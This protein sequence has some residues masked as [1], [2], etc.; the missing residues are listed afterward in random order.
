MGRLVALNKAQKMVKML[1]VMGRRDGVLAS[2]LLERFDLDPR[3]LRRYLADLRELNVPVIDTGRGDDRVVSLD[4]SWRRTGVQLTLTEVLSL[5]FGRT[6]FNFLD[7]TS[8]A[9]DLDDAIERLEPAVSRAHSSLARQLDT[10]FLAILEHAKDY[11]SRS[12]VI[13]EAITALVYNNPLHGRYRKP[14]G[15]EK[16]YRLEPY[17][18][19]TY[20]RGL[21]LLARDADEGMVKTFALERFT[22]LRRDRRQHFEPPGGWSP[23]A[24]LADAFGIISGPPSDIRVAFAP[25]LVAYIR[26]RTW[27]PTQT[28]DTLP[29]GR[30]VLQLRVA[31]TIEL[32]TWVLSFG[33]AAQ[34]LGP[35]SLVEWVTREVRAA[36]AMYTDV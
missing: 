24:H 9:R 19:A 15:V 26:E 17:T 20:R 7:G 29:D 30:L 1:R 12:D 6:L 14:T 5:H 28:F 21:Y 36:A 3:S 31:V 23:Q 25:E 33:G 32:V 16:H 22:H 27:H 11:R 8:F 10:K 35:S 4:P 34:A 13:D 2:E 18:L